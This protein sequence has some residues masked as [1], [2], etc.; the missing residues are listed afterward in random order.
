MAKSEEK[1]T[2]FSA[3]PCS[4]C[5]KKNFFFEAAIFTKENCYIGITCAECGN[6]AKITIPLSDALAFDKQSG[7]KDKNSA[8]GKR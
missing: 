7:G 1:Y 4:K 5:G 6:E 2:A 8:P 3:K